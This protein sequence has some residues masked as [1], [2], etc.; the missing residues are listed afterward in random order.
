[1]IENPHHAEMLQ[2]LEDDDLF[3]THLVFLEATKQLRVVIELHLEDEETHKYY[4]APMVAGN[5]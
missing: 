5:A 1:V 2:A 4:F 3:D